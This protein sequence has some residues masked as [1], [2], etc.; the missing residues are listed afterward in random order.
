MRTL[1]HPNARMGKVEFLDAFQSI[2]SGYRCAR[3]VTATAQ[4]AA[5]GTAIVGRKTPRAA[6]TEYETAAATTI[7]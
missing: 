4:P 1:E 5:K 2:R 3:S 6:G 7:A